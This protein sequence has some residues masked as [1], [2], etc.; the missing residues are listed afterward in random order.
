MCDL[1][2][3]AVWLCLLT[4]SMLAADERQSYFRSNSGI[5]EDIAVPERFDDPG[6]LDW[7]VP[8][9]P[10]ISTPCVAGDLIIVTTFEEKSGD[11]TTVALSKSDGTEVWRRPCPVRK[12]ED[13]HPVGSPASSTPATDGQH[14]YVFFGSYGLLCYDLEGRLVWQREMG[15]FQDEFGAS[16]SPVIAGPFVILNEDHD[17]GSHL[18]AIR[19]EDG[20]PAWKV[21]REEFTRSY[22][23][24]VLWKHGEV[25]EIVVAGSLR[26]TG[27]DLETG[28]VNWWVDGLS[29][30]VDST[31]VVAN[32]HLYVATWT[33][34][35][36]QANRISM[37]SFDDALKLY[38][39]NK[40]GFVQKSELSDGPILT[41]FFRIDLDQD[42]QL[43]Q[44]EWDKHRRV[45]DLAQNVAI[46]VRPGGRGN[47]TE[48]H[49]KWIHRRG[50]PTVPSPLVYRGHVYMVKDSGIVTVLDAETG[51]L[52]Y[53]GRAEGRGNYYASP[54]A[55]NGHVCFISERGVM[56]M[57]H[58]GATW[59]QAGSHD[60]GERILATPVVF[61]GRLLI[62]TDDAV[63]CFFKPK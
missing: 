17:V 2:C 3:K 38:D 31:P 48:T 49:V 16:S 11:L 52:E 21:D 62:R 36:D 25:T 7:T 13:F 44:P 5:Y 6:M 12:I 8:M 1:N 39:A 9:R 42:E 33:P 56:T 28:K 41:R 19:R 29:R 20:E 35:G 58:A 57:L 37:P 46:A 47:I 59:S 14:I 32:G 43:N 34:G 26:L 24:P 30:I 22:S 60:F 40:D 50:L 27:Y 4:T 45:F 10:G 53:Q 55:L 61:D 51:E 15:P 23:T 54:V 18:I 63:Y